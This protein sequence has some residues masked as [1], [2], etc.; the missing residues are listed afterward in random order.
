MTKATIP[1][2]Q[3]IERDLI[4][5]QRSL[6]EGKNGMTLL[7]TLKSRFPEAR[8]FHLL[9]WIPE[10]GEDIFWVLA[11]PEIIAI[12]EVARD[13]KLFSDLVSYKQISVQQYTERQLLPQSRRKLDIAIR[14][15]MANEPVTRKPGRLG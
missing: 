5:S 11:S 7:N 9:S 12:V 4:E 10:Q 1:S 2:D 3:E 6:H 8:G 15:L 14:L 13:G